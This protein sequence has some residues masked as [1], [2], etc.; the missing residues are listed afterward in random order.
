MVHFG[1]GPGLTPRPLGQKAGTETE[2]LQVNQ[3]PVHTHTLRAD[4]T[5]GDSVMPDDR[6]ISRV[7]RL[8]VFDNTSDVNMGNTAITATGG[9]QSHNN[10]QP[11]IAL[12]CI[13]ALQGIFPSRN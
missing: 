9:G 12:S 7:G 11:Y 6:V 5:G 3:L 13:I 8:R 1:N 10:T 4:S 2:A